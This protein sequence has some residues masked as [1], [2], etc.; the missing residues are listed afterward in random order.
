MQN[1]GGKALFF[2]Q[3]PEQQM[4]GSDMAMGQPFRFFR[5]I[6][7]HAFAL[8]AEGEIDRGRDFFPDGGV[9][10]DLLADRFHRGMRAQKSVGQG[11]IFAQE[12]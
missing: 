9:T 2:A 6:R 8:I 1:L 7:Q 3:Q 11:L 4:F 10:F 12:P 5:G